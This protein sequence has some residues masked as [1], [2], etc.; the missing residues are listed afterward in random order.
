MKFDTDLQANP[1]M[2]Q[3]LCNDSWQV[4]PKA[5]LNYDLGRGLGNV[6]F[7]VAKGYRSGGYNIQAYSDLSQ[8]LLQR[9]MMLG[10][11]D[12]SIATI[13]RLPLPDAMK[14]NAIKGMT[15]I[16]DKYTPAQPDAETLYYKPE[17]TWSYEVGT[18][19]NLWDKALQLDL[20]AFY[21]KTRDQQLARFAE[22]GMG[23]VM[24]NAG[25]SRSCGF[26]ASV[27]TSLLAERL[28]LSAA[29]GY[30][31]AV[32]T[33]Y[34]L[35]SQHGETVDYTD[36]RVPFVPE[37]T[38]S[39]TADFRQPLQHAV[40]KAVSVGAD[41]R[42]AGNVMWNEANTFSQHA[43]ANLAARVGLELA[44]N[45]SIEAWGRNLT[46][47]RYA[48]FSFDSMHNRFA[49]YNQPRHFGV[50]LRWKF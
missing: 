32:F 23:R 48:T 6:Y 15:G 1:A 50:D 39:V 49:Q 46:A 19:L 2:T 27:R 33:N 26:E 35:G 31:N 14:E 37:H 40:F 12:Y 22:S 38:F 13:N 10:V 4:L 28:L 42:G 25:R 9:E 17:Y 24:V 34:N 18:H 41:V 11:K 36:N 30:T 16:L 29:Y 8:S 47:S 3:K 21:M 20:S 5:A 43:Y 7:S 45:L 44:G